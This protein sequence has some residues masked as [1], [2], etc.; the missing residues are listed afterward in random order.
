MSTEFYFAVDPLASGAE[1][2]L[3]DAWLRAKDRLPNASLHALIDTAFDEVACDAYLRK[4]PQG[5]TVSLYA[6][7]ELEE[8]SS[9]SPWLVRLNCATPAS[10]T[11]ELQ[12]LCALRGNRP[13]LSFIASALDLAS[14]QQHFIPFLRVI[15]PENEAPYLLRFADTR[16]VESFWGALTP[17]QWAAF[18]P[19]DMGFWFP[20]R[21]AG[22]VGGVLPDTQRPTGPALNQLSF[23]A[24]QFGILLDAAEADL[25]IQ[26]LSATDPDRFATRRPS[27]VHAFIEQQ[28]GRARA[29]GLVDTPDFEVY[30]M[31]AWATGPEFDQHPEFAYAI[32]RARA[33]GELASCL[34]GVPASAWQAATRPGGSGAGI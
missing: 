13:M 21:Q 20:R 6:G 11:Q 26:R 34:G 8:L 2:N 9:V 12:A 23:D 19:P 15:L 17:A 24:Q 25:V 14:L 7:T 27:D 28:I 3:S 32:Q 29:H 1:A 4:R 16:I 22:S 30:C 31:A 18:L 5:S 10:L 33:P